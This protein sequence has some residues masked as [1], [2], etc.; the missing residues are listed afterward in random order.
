VLSQAKNSWIVLT[1]FVSQN[2]I[3]RRA[4]FWSFDNEDQG[5]KNSRKRKWAKSL[6]GSTPAGV[7]A[8]YPLTFLSS[9]LCKFC[10]RLL[11]EAERKQHQ[12]QFLSTTYKC[13]LPTCAEHPLDACLISFVS[14]CLGKNN[15]S[16]F[17]K[18]G[19]ILHLRR[20]SVTQ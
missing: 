1:K 14:S 3:V 9:H 4:L 10:W 12:R 5:V 8:I 18:T 20:I 2:E 19:F 13:V 11:V 7:Q 16:Q 17:G 6:L 15:F